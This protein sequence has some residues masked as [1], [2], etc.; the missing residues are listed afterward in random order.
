MT[1]RHNLWPRFS[2]FADQFGKLSHNYKAFFNRLYKRTGP[3]INPVFD[4]S[5]NADFARAINAILAEMRAQGWIDADSRATGGLYSEAIKAVCLIPATGDFI[6]GSRQV[7]YHAGSS[8]TFTGNAH[9]PPA[10]SPLSPTAAYLGDETDLKV[11]LDDLAEKAPNCR[12][13]SIFSTWFGSDLRCG[14]C[15]IKP[16]VERKLGAGE[17]TPGYVNPAD[18]NWG[19]PPIPAD[20]RVQGISRGD[21]ELITTFGG[22][23][24]YGSTPSD[25]TLIEAIQEIKA[26]GFVVSFTPF[27]LMDIEAGNTLTDPY[28]GAIGQPEYPWRG[29][30]TCSP[31]P[32]EAGTPDKTAA[33]ATQVASFVGTAAPGDFFTAPGPVGDE[34]I[35]SGPSEWSYRR[36]ILHYAK[37][38]ALAGGVDVFVIGSEQRGL[39][40]VREN[41]DTHP[42]VTALKALAADVKTILPD[43]DIVYAAD[44]SEYSNYSPGDGTNDLIFHLDPLWSDPNIDAIGIDNYFPLADWRDGTNHLDY[45]AGYTSIYDINY[46]QS[47]IQGGERF[48][49][50]YASQADRDAQ[51][52][53]PITDGAYGKPWV[54]RTKDLVSWW[55]NRHYN[56]IG[57]VEQTNSTGWVPESKPIWFAEVGCPS[58]NKGSNQPNV[59][60]DQIS[61]EAAFPYY[62][63]EEPDTLI[64]QRH[65]HAYIRF[66]DPEDEGFVETNNPVSS[67][68]GGRMVDPDRIYL[69]TWDARPY[70]AF[71]NGL[72]VWSDGVNWATG[73]WI[74]GKVP[75]P[76]DIQAVYTLALF[77]ARAPRESRIIDP[78]TGQITKQWREFFEGIGF[79][80]GEAINDLSTDNPSAAEIAETVNAIL[81]V[82][83]N[84]NRIG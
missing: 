56:R 65:N 12:Y 81:T 40:W 24:A 44:W 64:Q 54:F 19:Y 68:Y 82:L 14:N 30:I 15:E 43:A 25:I 69:Y 4:V 51:I 26:R 84:Q 50:F 35:Y 10:G 34:V 39:T 47:N 60:V 33:A 7:R 80:R 36:F 61:S 18:P 46:L 57:G 38:C 71:P 62:S 72:T 17:L 66:L 83:R 67:V 28:T 3:P 20:W 23:P 70:P 6:Y 74:T 63:N 41:A 48:D 78:Q 32:G 58:V 8:V 42:F 77:D 76:A 49:W 75:A 21:A 55:S 59:F 45:L 31:A 73:Q 37:L 5:P 27:L 16:K 2:T 9:Q 11:S 13:V 52:R 1:G 29:R 22:N 79:T 53:T